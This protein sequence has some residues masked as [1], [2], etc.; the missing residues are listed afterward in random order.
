MWFRPGLLLVLLVGSSLLFT[1]LTSVEAQLGEKTVTIGYLGNSSA[2]LE[3]NQVDGFRQGLRDLGY[4][5]GRNLIIKYQWAQGRL[6][7]H[8]ELAAE[9]VRLKV[10]VILTG[11]TP[12]AL[13]AKRATTSIP[14]V[15]VGVGDPLGAGLVSSLAKPGANVTGLA[16]LARELEGKR[17]ELLKAVVPSVSR[18]AVLMNPANPFTALAWKGMQPAADTLGVQLEPV[19]VRVADEF[20]QAF[21]RIT[22]AHTDA[23]VHGGAVCRGRLSDVLRSEYHRS[24]PASSLLRGRDPERRQSQ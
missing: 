11:G 21:A 17:L 23:F 22:T 3:S 14:I 8:R 13:A 4:E 18:V 24:L 15:M 2:R 5:E 7:R 9:L 10:D 16:T 6:E 20:D 1:L 19:E 12:G